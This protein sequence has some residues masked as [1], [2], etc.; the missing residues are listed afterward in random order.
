MK[1]HIHTKE[2][3]NK[4]GTFVS[5]L[6]WDERDVSK[7]NPKGLFKRVVQLIENFEG[8]YEIR[9]MKDGDTYIVSGEGYIITGKDEEAIDAE[10]KEGFLNDVFKN[11]VLTEVGSKEELW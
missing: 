6:D 8:K 2:I 7:D 1:S 9:Y 3:E 4:N 11:L 5:E 10:I